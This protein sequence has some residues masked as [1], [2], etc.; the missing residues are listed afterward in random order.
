MKMN[1]FKIILLLFILFVLKEA[2][3]AKP[4]FLNDFPKCDSNSLFRLKV[5]STDDWYLTFSSIFQYYKCVTRDYVKLKTN[6]TSTCFENNCWINCMSDQHYGKPKITRRSKFLSDVYTNIQEDCECDA[7]TENNDLLY[8]YYSSAKP[9]RPTLPIQTTTKD[10]LPIECYETDGSSCEW[11]KDCL[12][13]RYNCVGT[14]ADYAIKYALK[15][16]ELYNSNYDY[17]SLKGKNWINGV[18][19]CLQLAL[20]QYLRPNN[21]LDCESLKNKAFES[22]AP[23]YLIP[24]GKETPSLCDLSCID[25]MSVFWTIKSSFI[26][27]D[28]L[29]ALQGLIDVAF[30]RCGIKMLSCGLQM[31]P[32]PLLGL[33]TWQFEFDIY[34][35]DEFRFFYFIDQDKIATEITDL[36]SRKLNLDSN[37]L[38]WFGFTPKNDSIISSFNVKNINLNIWIGEKNVS[39]NSSKSLKKLEKIEQLLRDQ[40]ILTEMFLDDI[41]F[42]NIQFKIKSLKLCSDSSCQ[43]VNNTISFDQNKHPLLNSSTRLHKNSY[44]LSNSIFLMCFLLIFKYR[45]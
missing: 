11:Y 34:N 38:D 27:K 44:L 2:S 26:S 16:C 15:F 43:M 33:L 45:N 22:H 39:F 3:P 20:V 21:K 28:F 8:E 5:C 18:R 29:K 36:I 14:E 17:F 13:K 10:I 4:V 25:F 19:K 24:S 41:E 9:F 31:V 30:S 32:N 42:N 37:Y 40:K 1:N 12:E 23:C 7:Y 6:G 35:Q